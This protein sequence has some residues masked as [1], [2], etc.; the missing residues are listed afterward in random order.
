VIL[1]ASFPEIIQHL[2][3]MN[4]YIP[5][6]LNEITVIKSVENWTNS[7]VR[8]FGKVG[9]SI[10][11]PPESELELRYLHS[12]GEE[13]ASHAI[14]NF[15]LISETVNR[16][17]HE[18]SIVQILGDLQPFE[19]TIEEIKYLFIVTAHIIRDFDRV[20]PALYHQASTQQTIAC[21]RTFFMRDS[22]NTNAEENEDILASE[23]KLYV[24]S[25][26]TKL[27]TSKS[28]KC[29]NNKADTKGEPSKKVD[30]CDNDSSTDMFADSD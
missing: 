8:I 5:F 30:N 26:K 21:P 4:P 3:E 20:D 10:Y 25:K 15:G 17:F 18:G 24:D 28:S 23:H 6:Q 9:Q 27:N 1:L 11:T 12:V 7:R 19:S 14:A 16:N 22:R 13:I 2:N 29:V